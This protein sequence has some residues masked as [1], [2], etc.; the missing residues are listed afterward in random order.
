VNIPVTLPFKQTGDNRPW[1]KT[2][3]RPVEVNYLR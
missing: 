2:N 3:C 1:E